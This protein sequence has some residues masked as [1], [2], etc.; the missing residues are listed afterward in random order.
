MTNMSYS[1]D[2]RKV[3]I[4]Y[5]QNGHTFEELKQVFKV[6]RQTYYNWLKLEEETGSLKK[7]NADSRN[8]KIDAQKLKQAVEEKPDAYLS[9]LA[10]LFGCTPQAVFYALKK[11]KITYKKN[12][13]V[14]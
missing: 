3:A 11:L 5:K 4:E 8:R 1:S 14:L 12:L 2:Y 6:T 7:R 10:E 9:E 13:H